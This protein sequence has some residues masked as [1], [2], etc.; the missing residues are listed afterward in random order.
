MEQHAQHT[1]GR[2]HAATLNIKI[3]TIQWEY[4]EPMNDTSLS[5]KKQTN[6]VKNIETYP[7]GD[8]I[9][10]VMNNMIS[11]EVNVYTVNLYEQ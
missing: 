9:I 1:T 10:Y 4:A 6:T 8:I 5:H 7:I 3:K 11:F 2:Q